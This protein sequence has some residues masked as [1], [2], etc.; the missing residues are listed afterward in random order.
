M[1]VKRDVERSRAYYFGEGKEFK[2]QKEAISMA[3]Y[4][5]DKM[6]E[7]LKDKLDGVPQIVINGNMVQVEIPIKW[8]S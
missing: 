8:E 6:L 2:N 4:K 5:R 1:A 7:E 3:E